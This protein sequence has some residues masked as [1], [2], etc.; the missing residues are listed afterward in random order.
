MVSPCQ[1]LAVGRLPGVFRMP[2]TIDEGAVRCELRIRASKSGQR[3]GPAPVLRATTIAVQLQDRKT[4]TLQNTPPV[5]RSDCLPGR[6]PSQ[7]VYHH[8]Y[9]AVECR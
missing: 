9:G 7:E 5:L 6:S 2:L 3:S 4:D 8:L 1:I